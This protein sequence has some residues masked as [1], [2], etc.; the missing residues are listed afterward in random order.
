MSEFAS[1]APVLIG[2]YWKEKIRAI[3]P[4]ELTPNLIR[5]AREFTSEL[6][7]DWCIT[8]AAWPEW[9]VNWYRDFDGVLNNRR[10]EAVYIDTEVLFRRDRKGVLLSAE[11]IERLD[12]FDPEEWGE[13]EDPH[14]VRTWYRDNVTKAPGK[15]IR[16]DNPQRW[17][18]VIN[19]LK[20]AFPA[21][22]QMFGVR[23][24]NDDPPFQVRRPK[25]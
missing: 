11:M 7:L 6:S 21:R 16:I 24:A 18:A 1:F 9:L 20:I 15:R 17:A 22:A 19:I 2:D 23:P 12:M 13:T 14:H 10:G 4:A 3:T 25:S 5:D 8:D